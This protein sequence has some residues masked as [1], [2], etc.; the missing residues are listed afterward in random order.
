M[1][2]GIATRRLGLLLPVLVVL[3]IGYLAPMAAIAWTSLH[4][5][6]HLSLG[7]Y[8]EVLS[9]L[10]FLRILLRTLSIAGIVT[11][12]CVVS[13]Y[14]LA[15]WAA[16]RARSWAR[17][18][19]ALVMVP[20]LTS[21][22]IRSYAWIVILGGDGLINHTLLALGLIETPLPLVFSSTG[23]IIGMVHILLP[24]AV[25]PIYAGMRQ[26]APSLLLA[27]Q[28]LGGGAA[29]VFV[30]VFLPLS[31]PGVVAGAALV[32]LSAVGFYITPA[33]LGAPGDYLMAQAIEVRVSTLAEFDVAAALAWLLLLLVGSGLIV[34]SRQIVPLPKENASGNSRHRRTGIGLGLSAPRPL[35][36]LA[37]AGGWVLARFLPVAA[38]A[39]LAFL[40]APMVVVLLIAF[41]NAP[42]L[43]FPP[44]GYS[45][46][47]VQVFVHD[48]Q[49]L[50]SL[51][52]SLRLAGAAA[53]TCLAVGTPYALAL[54]RGH[55]RGRRLLWL[56]AVS[57]M[58]LPHIIIGL[59]FFFAAVAIGMNGRAA[60][61]WLAYTVIGLPYVVIILVSALG[62]FDINLERAAVNLGASPLTA[63]ATITVPILAA[64]FAGAF[65]FAFLAGFDDLIISLFLSTPRGTTIAIRIWEDIRL[66]IS[67]KTAVVGLF[68]VGVVLIGLA[69]MTIM[70]HVRRPKG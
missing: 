56:L 41:S 66:E 42:Y 68:Q 9:S 14:L 58:I 35:I 29:S 49:W 10:T 37:E 63:L 65:L 38:I 61:F 36:E 5:V 70:R 28:S 57:P 55:F 60:S 45:W 69:G 25:L 12:I 7:A 32:F 39:L 20:Y 54:T 50:D 62:R 13:G 48:G 40:L 23:N 4:R 15:Y 21:V 64:S 53:L 11:A 30:T 16:T 18:I 22:L 26:I 2:T 24:L 34:F 46:R 33:L 3:S 31:I 67:P 6:G 59:G 17:S 19:M 43:T 52:F 44:P 8:V 47:W 27:A 51:W 1:M